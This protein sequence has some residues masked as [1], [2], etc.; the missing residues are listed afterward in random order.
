MILSPTIKTNIIYV[1]AL[2]HI[3]LFTYAAVSK[4]IDFQNFTIQLGQSPLLT[5]Y[6]SFIA[7]FIPT[8]EIVLSI[9]L[10]I[11][12]YRNTALSLSCFLMFLFTVYIVMILNFTSFVPCSCGG[13]LE[14]LGW[15]EH[16]IFNAVF[17]LL[18]LIAILLASNLKHTLIISAIVGSIAIA[19][20]SGLFLLSEDVMQNENP[21]I[22][23]FPQGAAAQVK[24]LDLRNT[25]FYIAGISQNNIYLGNHQ[26][27][28][29]VFVIDKSLNSRKQFS[30]TLDH[31]HSRLRNITLKVQGDHFYAFD[32]T[33]PIIYSGSTKD[34]KAYTISQDKYAFN[35]IAF[36]SDYDVIIRGQKPG[37][38]DNVLAKVT[39]TDS[40]TFKLSEKLLQKQ[41]DGFFDTDGILNYSFEYNM[42][43]YTYYYRNQYIVSDDHLQLVHRGNTIDTT[44]KAKIS[45]ARVDK[46]GDTKLSAPPVLVN[47]FTS[48]S[49]N[50]L[51]VN[52]MLRGKFEN[53]K[54]WKDATAVDVY[55]FTTNKYLL[56]FYVYDFN[57]FRMKNMLT[58]PDAMYIIS[59]HYLLKYEFGDRL[60][61]KMKYKELPAGIR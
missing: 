40:L 51:F 5:I 59:G 35:D 18:G 32:G 14:K 41:I 19:I 24:Q 16:L 3:L 13:V 2:L 25:N 58:S 30:I 45:I 44:S 8:I 38:K 50:L 1:V 23:R 20:M 26:A 60:T 48:V 53:K 34:W 37:K 9:L 28:L 42:L 36:L 17:V 54:V 52:S 43:I 27:Q 47:K 46:S 39:G 33:A 55:D 22:R 12:R 10:M 49:A 21:F 6:A 7:Y 61:S 15:T 31:E 29:Q 56:S 57:G 11:P 4:I